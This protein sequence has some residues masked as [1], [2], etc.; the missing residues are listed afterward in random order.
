[1]VRANNQKQLEQPTLWL[2]LTCESMV[3][4]E[5]A[6]AGAAYAL[7]HPHM[8]EVVDPEWRARLRSYQN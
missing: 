6:K 8:I 3:E 5:T 2:I 7:A 4:T 1:M